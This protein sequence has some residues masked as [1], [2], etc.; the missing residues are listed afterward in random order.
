MKID[1]LAYLLYFFTL[2]IFFK[3]FLRF[4]IIRIDIVRMWCYDR[5]TRKKCNTQNTNVTS[6]F[7]F[8]RKVDVIFYDTFQ[9]TSSIQ[10]PQMLIITL[11][12][13]GKK[14]WDIQKSSISVCPRIFIVP[15]D[16]HPLLFHS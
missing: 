10:S 8:L 14:S 5:V 15:D 13:K 12:Q 7:I 9:L 6:V 16:K 3:N 4:L 1:F 11:H 2:K